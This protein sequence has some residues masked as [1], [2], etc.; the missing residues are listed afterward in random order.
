MLEVAPS[1][2]QTP[3]RTGYWW[4]MRFF[5]GVVAFLVLGNLL[6]LATHLWLHRAASEADAPRIPVHNFAVVDDHV[7]RGAAPSPRAYEA[8][9]DN[10]V[11]TIVD[12]R[13]E[14]DIRVDEDALTELGLT[15][16]HLPVR[17]GQAP[18]ASVVAR[19]LDVV[20]NSDGRVYVHCGAGVGRTGTMAAAY[21]VQRGGASSAEVLRRN[22][23]VGP[24]SLEQLA[25]ASR[26][27]QG[28]ATKAPTALVAV[29][30]VLDAPRRFWVGVRNSY[31]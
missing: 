5:V 17:D 18:P 20:A 1:N 24:P 15:R 9:A 12:L 4:A 27:R 16:V 31:Q 25:F 6:I 23:A 22:L 19:F 28:E 8:L 3:R 26:L 10:G 11:T 30:R 14:D 13:A 29:S 2:S 7:W 21:L